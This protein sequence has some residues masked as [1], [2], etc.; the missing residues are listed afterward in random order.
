MKKGDPGSPRKK[1]TESL[2]TENGRSTTAACCFDPVVRI[3]LAGTTSPP[4][5]RGGLVSLAPIGSRGAHR[6]AGQH[7]ASPFPSHFIHSS[8]PSVRSC[9]SW[10]WSCL[11]VTGF[12]SSGV[13]CSFGAV[14]C[15]VLPAALVLC[16]LMMF[17]DDHF[18]RSDISRSATFV[19]MLVVCET[20]CAGLGLGGGGGGSRAPDNMASLRTRDFTSPRKQKKLTPIT[21]PHDRRSLSKTHRS[22]DFLFLYHIFRSQKI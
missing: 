7:L 22:S 20:P 9:A 5:G 12:L 19:R 6:S 10:S 1:H 15:C 14:C 11:V 3:R 21:S 16:S 4:W 17:D 18:L 2:A 8:L 13:C